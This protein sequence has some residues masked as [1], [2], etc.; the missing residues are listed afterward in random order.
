M[1]KRPRGSGSTAP[2]AALMEPAGNAP[3]LMT[4]R[5]QL[6]GSCGCR[7]EDWQHGWDGCA[8]VGCSCP[9]SWTY[10]GRGTGS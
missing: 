10:R 8:V 9:A 1:T 7:H 4:T 6:A 3:P 2:P 5:Y